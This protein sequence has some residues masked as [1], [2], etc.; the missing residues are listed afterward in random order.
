MFRSLGRWHH[1]PRQHNSRTRS[2]IVL[3]VVAA[4]ALSCSSGQDPTGS[5]AEIDPEASLRIGHVG[6]VPSLDPTQQ[7]LGT[8]QAATFLL[9]DRL[10]QLDNNYEVQPMLAT[11]WEFAPDGSYLELKLRPGVTFHDGTP[12]DAG[13]VKGSLERMKTAPGS[14]AAPLL[15]DITSIQAVDATTVRLMLVA[16]RGAAL[17]AVLAS[18]AGEVMSLNALSDGRDLAMAPGDGGSGAYVVSEFKPN[19]IVVLE[20]SSTPYWDPEA[21]KPKRIEIRR[22]PVASVGL[23][24]LRSG[25]LDMVLT[26]ATDVESAQQLAQT[27]AAKV[28]EYSLLTPSHALFMNSAHPAFRDPRVRAAISM[29]ID[30]AAICRDLLAGNCEPRVQPYPDTHWAHAANLDDLVQYTPDKAKQALADAGAGNVRFPLVFSIG[31]SYETVAQVIQSQLAAAGITVDLMPLPTAE[32]FGGYREGRY[33][34]YLT[35]MLP[36]ADPAQL[37]DVTFLA[38]SNAAEAVRGQITPIAE[39]AERP[40]LSKEQRAA[41]YGQVWTEIAQSS[42]AIPI[43]SNRVAW[44]YSPKVIGVDKMPWGWS[45]YFDAR[46]LGVT[47]RA[48]LSR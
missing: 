21:A 33:P 20:R 2:G 3:A 22:T 43:I 35:T 32:A 8:E 45:G 6:P 39:Q 19:E 12:V 11:S 46:Y 47:N 29:A 37:M 26:T 40:G 10:T 34:A 17:P 44:A 42:A 18:H 14:T 4:L 41:L 31:S 30:R 28:A 38:G 36:A 1:S 9:Y 15:T 23:N 27:G 16:G 25:Q 13:A 24:A 48:E 5:A 7:T